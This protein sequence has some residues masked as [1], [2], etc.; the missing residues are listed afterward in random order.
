[1]Y[2]PT[3]PGSKLEKDLHAEEATSKK[4]IWTSIISSKLPPEEKQAVVR[5]ADEAFTLVAAGGETTAR[6]LCLALFHV[7]ADKVFIMPHLME[8][9]VSAMPETS[10][11][12]TLK[13]LEQLPW[14]VCVQLHKVGDVAS[15]I[16]TNVV[17]TGIVKETLRLG[18]IVT[19]RL[20]LVAPRETLRYAEWCIPPGVSP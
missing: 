10:T 8:E 4:N 1:M 16:C 14:L 5:M 13:A 15:R 2:T 7:L 19:S 12:P 9:L 3:R 18:G 11:Y 6:A 17:Q 20:P